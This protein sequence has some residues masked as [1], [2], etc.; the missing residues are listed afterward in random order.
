MTSADEIAFGTGGLRS[1]DV[2][3]EAWQAGYRVFDTAVY[4]ANDAELFAALDAAGAGEEARIVHK[5]QPYRVSAQFE[6]L[7]R[8]KLGGRPLDTL[9][10]HHP[11]L[12][13]LDAR[14]GAL[15]K[16]WSELERLVERGL[17]RRIGCSNAGP[18]FIEYLFAHASVKPAVNQVECHPGQYDAELIRCCR[19]RGVEVQCY[20]P[21][22]SGRLPIL[23]S[24]AIQEVARATHRS[25]AQ[26]CL[27]W[28]I[29]KGLVP[30]VRTA[31]PEHMRDNRQALGFSLNAAQMAAIDQIGQSGR[32]WDDP[33]K[34]GGLSGTV[35]PTRIRVPNPVRFAIRSAVHYGVVELFLRRRAR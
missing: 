34:R 14:P 18:S 13:V 4:Y 16:P 7:I 20:S 19:E 27:R 15:M 28:S 33:I 8:P 35:T 6:R 21:L 10:L 22:G 12:F 2:F 24:T 11:A 26:V 32:A 23:K 25:A 1:A 9:L 31:R 30:I 29:Q 3:R 5:V 17:V